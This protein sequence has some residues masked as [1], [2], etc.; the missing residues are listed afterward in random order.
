MASIINVDTINEK[1]TG[2]GVKIPGHVV[3]VVQGSTSTATTNTTSSFVDT[4]LTASI[5]PLFSSSKILVMVQQQ[6]CKAT[7]IST[8]CVDMKL[9]RNSSDIYNFAI[10]Y[11]Y[12]YVSTEFRSDI[13]G[14]YLDSPSTTSAT[15]YKTVFRAN[16]GGTSTVQNDGANTVS[17]ITLMEIA[18]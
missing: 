3:Q 12:G 7:L 8:G 9:Q 6:G 2:N 15:T 5:T 16:N 18:Q 1:T 4:G 17:T 10:A 11:F 13:S 14:C